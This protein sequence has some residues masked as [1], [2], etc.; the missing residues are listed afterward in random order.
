[1]SGRNEVVVEL[2]IEMAEYVFALFGWVPILLSSLSLFLFLSFA[3]LH[4]S[5][6]LCF[7]SLACLYGLLATPILLISIVALLY[8][9]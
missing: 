8:N 7:R 3:F 6:F 1:M 2:R 9:L 4:C 5:V